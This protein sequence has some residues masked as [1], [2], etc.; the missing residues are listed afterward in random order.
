MENSANF[1]DVSI[2]IVSWNTQ[3]LLR[4]CLRSIFAQTT[5]N[6]FE[7]IVIDNG[8]SD[9]SADMVQREFDRVRLLT[10]VENNGFAAANNQG[11]SVAEG[12]YLL[13]LNSDTI[14]L[15]HAIEK[16]VAFADVHPDAAVVGCRLLN[17]DHTLQI[18]CFMFPSPLN[19]LLLS[20]GAAHFFPQSRFFGRERMTWWDRTDLREVDV[21]TGCF[22][23]VRKKAIDEIGP[24][25]ERFFMYNEETDWCYRF[26]MKGWKNWFT[27]DAEIVHIGGASAAKLGTRRAKLENSSFVQYMFKHWSKPL[28]L[29]G[30]FLLGLFYILRLVVLVPMYLVMRREAD[31]KLIEHFW[32]GLKNSLLYFYSPAKPV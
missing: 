30:L 15:D 25:D 14:I 31:R 9:G 19:L 10:N 22:M 12:R 29:I 4:Q 8:S 2:I 18:S 1:C 11:I 23:L 13:L 3:D 5:K 32:A 7:V 16:V 6:N 24:M 26:K 17:P 27:A 28:A 20:T 21:V